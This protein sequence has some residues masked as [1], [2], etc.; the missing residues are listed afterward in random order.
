MQC[1][2]CDITLWSGGRVSSI[3]CTCSWL[4]GVLLLTTTFPA[5][6]VFKLTLVAML[7]CPVVQNLFH[8]PLEQDYR[9]LQS[10]YSCRLSGQHQC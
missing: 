4:P 2:Y 7:G 10:R 6:Q 3:L 1:S 9:T 8:S 5:N